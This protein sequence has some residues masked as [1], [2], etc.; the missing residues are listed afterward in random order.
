MNS[1]CNTNPLIL[2][3]TISRKRSSRHRTS[4]DTFLQPPQY[5][6]PQCASQA[7]NTIYFHTYIVP[8]H[9]TQH[10]TRNQHTCIISVPESHWPGSP[11]P[12]EGEVKVQE[13]D[14]SQKDEGRTC[15][16]D[17]NDQD[18]FSSG[19]SWLLGCVVSVCYYGY[20]DARLQTLWI[21]DVLEFRAGRRKG[22]SNNNSRWWWRK[23]N[24]KKI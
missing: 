12:H 13:E 11:R 1:A 20:D 3:S 22:R 4:Q 15:Q 5:P 10:W 8:P 17:P 16:K 21:N 14:G 6:V 18:C 23:R 2:P 19:N 9:F 24:K 7:P